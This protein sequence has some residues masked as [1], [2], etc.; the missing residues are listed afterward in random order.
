M[1]RVGSM[2]KPFPVAGEGKA[3]AF[4]A[5]DGMIDTAETLPNILCP[6]RS[7]VPMT[8]RRGTVVRGTRLVRPGVLLRTHV[9]CVEDNK[10]AGGSVMKSCGGRQKR[11]R[12]SMVN[13]FVPINSWDDSLL[14][15]EAEENGASA[16]VVPPPWAGRYVCAVANKL[17]TASKKLPAVA[18][19]IFKNA[20]GDRLSGARVDTC[21]HKGDVMPLLV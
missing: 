2:S 11:M 18:L 6:R 4:A 13:V 20:V 12:W 5:P 3:D 1:F 14:I 8:K 9:G 19:V 17:E 7:E 21:L 10:G 15:V 16:T